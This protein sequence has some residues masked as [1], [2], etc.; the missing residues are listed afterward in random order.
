MESTAE[1]ARKP[2]PL[3]AIS[4]PTAQLKI[5]T[6]CAV[7]GRCRAWI[8]KKVREGTFPSPVKD[9]A[10]CTRWIA[11]DVSAWLEKQVTPVAG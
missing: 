2:Q 10:R 7:T 9:G 8:Y 1:R 5:D 4:V 3:D 6:V 11:R